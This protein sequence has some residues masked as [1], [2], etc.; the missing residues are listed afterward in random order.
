MIPANPIATPAAVRGPRYRLAIGD[1]A[2]S[3]AELEAYVRAAFLRKHRAHV[4]TFMPVLLAL[5]DRAERLC[6]V[7]GYRPAAEGTLYLEQYLD[8][9]VEQ[10]LARATGRPVRRTAVVEVGHLAAANCRSAR[11]LA[12]QMPALLLGAG[13]EWIV[14]T[15]TRVVRDLL[16]GFDAP[17]HDLGAADRA[18]LASV[19]DD[20][21]GYYAHDPRVLAGWLPHSRAL[22][23]F[24][25][26][27]DH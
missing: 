2:G 8:V 12:A 11:S 17:L 3:R 15:G 10:A 21:G 22:A 1:A 14:F 5:R 26:E 20:W 4:A 6:G 27:F 24:A 13:Y 7:A 25:G 9:P 19:A 23:P 18:R 16:A